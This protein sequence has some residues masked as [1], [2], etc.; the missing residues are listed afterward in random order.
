MP[1]ISPAPASGLLSCEE[2]HQGARERRQKL[3]SELG[4]WKS[5]RPPA[6]FPGHR[7]SLVILSPLV[8]TKPSN[9]G[10]LLWNYC[11]CS[12]PPAFL[13]SSRLLLRFLLQHQ[14]HGAFTRCPLCSL[15]SSVPSR[16]PLL[17]HLFAR[18]NASYYTVV[19]YTLRLKTFISPCLLKE[20]KL[21]LT[22][23]RKSFSSTSFVKHMFTELDLLKVLLCHFVSAFCLF[24]RAALGEKNTNIYI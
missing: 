20:T 22:P 9:I 4:P 21:L 1:R 5:Q 17:S 24:L 7:F 3:T 2:M 10:L 18:S 6:Q 16:P 15:Y 13:H 19:I 14:V 11:L 8:D 23:L 12:F